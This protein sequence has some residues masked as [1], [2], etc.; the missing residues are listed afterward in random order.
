MPGMKA[1][2]RLQRPLLS[3]CRHPGS[4]KMRLAIV[5]RSPEVILSRHRGCDGSLKSLAHTLPA[6]YGA[7]LKGGYASVTRM[8]A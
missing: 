3:R 4:A 8:K 7:R 5:L 1:G 6:D 2:S